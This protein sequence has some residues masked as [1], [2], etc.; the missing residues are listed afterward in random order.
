MG[1]ALSPFSACVARDRQMGGAY[2]FLLNSVG[3]SSDRTSALSGYRANLLWQ[4]P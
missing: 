3:P 4:L 2:T 1:D